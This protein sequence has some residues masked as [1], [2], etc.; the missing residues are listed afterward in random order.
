MSYIGKQWNSNGLTKS[1][2]IFHA[3]C[4][5]KELHD[6]TTSYTYTFSRVMI[7]QH[8]YFQE[9]NS[10]GFNEIFYVTVLEVNC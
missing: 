10:F 2:Q 8:M 1:V 4:L 7:N 9:R 5:Q 6:Y 3:L